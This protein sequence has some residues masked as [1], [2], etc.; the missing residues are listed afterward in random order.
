MTSGAPTGTASRNGPHVRTG[1]ASTSIG[2]SAALQAVGV[3]SRFSSFTVLSS[4]ALNVAHPHR[5]T[6]PSE[7][8]E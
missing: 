2:T 7:R 4:G 1:A 5:H 8:D 6:Q 3:G